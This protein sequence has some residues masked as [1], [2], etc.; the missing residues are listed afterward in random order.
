VH[1]GC[2]R[3]ANE[4]SVHEQARTTTVAGL[5]AVTIGGAETAAGARLGV[6]ADADDVD[7][8]DTYAV[9][10][11]A[12]GTAVGVVGVGVGVGVDND[13]MAAALTA[14]TAAESARCLRMW[15]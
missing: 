11:A 7:A 1:G 4:W 10:T 8:A 13:A 9:Q 2:S 15:L 5:A 6:Y 3:P 14:H 12:A